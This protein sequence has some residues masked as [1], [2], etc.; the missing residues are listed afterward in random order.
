MDICRKSRG[1][2]K[3]EEEEQTEGKQGKA[4][5]K[6]KMTERGGEEKCQTLFLSPR[7]M[8]K[9]ACCKESTVRIRI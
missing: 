4:E 5:K 7:I 8:F 2:N 9:L 3:T 1:K 6:E